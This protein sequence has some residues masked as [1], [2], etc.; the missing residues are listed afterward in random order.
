MKS[1]SVRDVKGTSVGKLVK[2]KGMVTRVSNVKPLAIVSAY[3][4]ESCGNEV[5]QDV[6]DP[7]P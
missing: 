4:C 3:S 5:F 6:L 7:L 2:L 1:L